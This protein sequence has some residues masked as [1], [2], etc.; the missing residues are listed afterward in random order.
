MYRELAP[1]P[2]LA[3]VV[4]CFWTM[5]SAGPLPG[6]T[7]ERVLPDGCSDIIFHFG[8]GAPPGQAHSGMGSYVVG[9]MPT[10]AVVHLEGAV[11]LLGVRFRPGGLSAVTGMPGEEVVGLVVALGE[12]VPGLRDEPARLA[13]APPAQ[14]VPLV[15][16]R[17]RRE[18]ARADRAMD[19]RVRL[20]AQR[21]ERSAGATPVAD[22]AR[23]AGVSPRQLERLY[24]REVG[25]TPREAR[26]VARFRHAV[27]CLNGQPAWNIARVAHAT[28]YHDQSHL[29]RDFVR[30]AGLTPAAYRRERH[31]ASVQDGPTPVA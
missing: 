13:D 7:S 12:A 18:L 27:R 15:A 21:I 5:R 23:A 31:V 1:P 4:E 11:D 6:R 14:R 20:V 17:I 30:L 19:P 2:G 8:D 3:S 10:A 26:R 28:G 25:L 16:A 29:H 24:R 9:T 22:L